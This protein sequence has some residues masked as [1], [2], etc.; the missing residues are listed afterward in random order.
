M[1]ISSVIAQYANA[2][3]VL[4]NNKISKE[5]V[6]DK[7]LSYESLKFEE[8]GLGNS[9]KTEVYIDENGNLKTNIT[10]VYPKDH[11]EM[12]IGEMLSQFTESL[13][14]SADKEIKEDGKEKIVI[15]HGLDDLE[16][17]NSDLPGDT[18]KYIVE[19][20]SK[21]MNI[22]IYEDKDD[23]DNL[24]KPG[25]VGGLLIANEEDKADLGDFLE[26]PHQFSENLGSILKTAIRTYNP[27]LARMLHNSYDYIM[28]MKDA[29]MIFKM[30]K[31]IDEQEK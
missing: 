14:Y 10:I 20:V 19:E 28:G 23:P 1:H 15:H 27:D 8:K 7:I 16:F 5:F 13:L 24:Y 26:N 18:K 6:R 31:K 9:S 21:W 30:M 17:F 2:I 4:T 11:P 3:R 29:K 12:A 22:K 25:Y